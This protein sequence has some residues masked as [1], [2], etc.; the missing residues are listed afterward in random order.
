MSN[1]FA[2]IKELLCCKFT[3][4]SQHSDAWLEED[5]NESRLKKIRL[6]G[7]EK[8]MLL[9][10]TDIKQ[11]NIRSNS[12]V[13]MSRLFSSEDIG[14]NRICDYVL[15]KYNKSKIQIYY[16][17]LKSNKP[18]GYVNQFKS[19]RC[20]MAYVFALMKDLREIS[21]E[22]IEQKFIVIHTTKNRLSI[23]KKPTKRQKENTTPDQPKKI[24]IKESDTVRCTQ[25]F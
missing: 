13:N 21:S 16:I 23:N 1:S 10:H 17:E 3:D 14:H 9:L 6:T 8:G 25:F 24:P 7:L 4:G 20:F 22:I 18:H 2:A 11:K 15:L 5:Q 12:V 19:T